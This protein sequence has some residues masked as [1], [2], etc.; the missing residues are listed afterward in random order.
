LF[1]Q[2]LQQVPLLLL[3]LEDLGKPNC[4]TCTMQRQTCKVSP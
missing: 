1:L 2:G 3:L 4:T